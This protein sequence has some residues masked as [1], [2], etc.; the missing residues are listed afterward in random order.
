[1]ETIMR[2]STVQWVAAAFAAAGLCGCAATSP[3]GG[4]ADRALFGGFFSDSHARH[5]NEAAYRIDVKAC[6]RGEAA[7]W[8]RL[9]A[10]DRNLARMVP[11]GTHKRPVSDPKGAFVYDESLCAGSLAGDR[12]RG[13]V[14]TR[15]A[16]PPV[17]H[18]QMI[19]ES[20]S[21]PTF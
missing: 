11:V 13:A 18:G 10:D 3:A 7:E 8:C 2:T 17:C 9:G 14:I 6:G 16:P 21:G 12:C 5:A 15:P 19:D 1:V 4:L 20:C